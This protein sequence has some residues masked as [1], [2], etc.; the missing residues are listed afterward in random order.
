MMTMEVKGLKLLK[1]HI[2]REARKLDYA[3]NQAANYLAKAIREEQKAEMRRVFDRPTPYTL[4][5]LWIKYAKKGSPWAEV[6]IKDKSAAGKGTAAQDYLHPQIVGGG[7][8]RKR[9]ER[10]LEWAGIMPPGYYAVPAAGARLDRYGNMSRGQIVQILSWFRAFGEQGYRANITD[11][12]RRRRLRGTRRRYGQG[13]FHVYPGREKNRHLHP[14]IYQKTRLAWGW[15]IKP[16]L[17]F[18]P[19]VGYR[20]RFDFYGIAER[21]YNRRLS[22]ALRYGLRRAYA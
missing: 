17:L 16:V 9:F 1:R 14:G 22:E 5:S 15:A 18:V 10:A 19:R 13:Y 2:D 11:E 4:N 21:T 3:M 12:G 7:R 8:K 20:P 6:F